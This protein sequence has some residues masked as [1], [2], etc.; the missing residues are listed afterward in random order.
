[1]LSKILIVSIKF[2]VKIPNV[3]IHAYCMMGVELFHADRQLERLNET[4]VAVCSF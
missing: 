4:D 1:M 2:L 3:N